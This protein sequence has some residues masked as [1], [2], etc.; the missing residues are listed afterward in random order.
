MENDEDTTKGSDRPMVLISLIGRNSPQLPHEG[1]ANGDAGTRTL[2]CFAHR[3]SAPC[4][5]PL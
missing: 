5:T 3:S 4:L 2:S 1:I